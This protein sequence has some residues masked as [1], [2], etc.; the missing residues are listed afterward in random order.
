MARNRTTSRL[1]R[2][3]L[4]VLFGVMSL[5][6]GP[7]MA[8]AKAGHGPVEGIHGHHAASA[9]LHAG[10]PDAAQHGHEHADRDQPVPIAA[11]GPAACF[12]FGCFVAM[13]PA[14][15]GAPDAEWLSLGRLSPRPPPAVAPALQKPTDPPPRLQD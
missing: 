14:P 9:G 1:F 2:L 3:A 12:S 10:R 15:S 4:A 13:S 6:H 8:F 5:S 7:V 11:D